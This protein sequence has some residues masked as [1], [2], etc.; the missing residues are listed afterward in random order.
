MKI[1]N[2]IWLK[3]LNDIEQDVSY[4]GAVVDVKISKTVLK[5]EVIKWL[6]HL[7]IK[8][9]NEKGLLIDVSANQIEWI[10]HFFNITKEDLE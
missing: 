1:N 10:R 3:T 7:E 6:K 9:E 5:Y 4:E 2:E 8:A